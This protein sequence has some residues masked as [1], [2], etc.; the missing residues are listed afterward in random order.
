ML[1]GSVGIL[2]ICIGLHLM[3]PEIPTSSKENA[4]SVVKIQILQWLHLEG[5]W[6]VIVAT[7]R[8]Q[9]GNFVNLCTLRKIVVSVL[10]LM[11]ATPSLIAVPT[12][13]SLCA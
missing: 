9:T 7:R 4:S 1:L 3:T 5:V 13:M 2:T 12:M 10:V 8:V 11:T 6:S